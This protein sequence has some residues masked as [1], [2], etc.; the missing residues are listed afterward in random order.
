MRSAWAE[1]GGAI[2]RGFPA[3]N[4]GQFSASSLSQFFSRARPGENNCR[5]HLFLYCSNR[6]YA[7]DST[8]QAG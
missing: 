8:G 1:R 2:Y 7:F 3:G 6:V 4:R 5:S